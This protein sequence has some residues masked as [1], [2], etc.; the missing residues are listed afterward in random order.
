MEEAQNCLKLYGIRKTTVDELVKRVNIPKG[1][2]YLFYESKE[3]LF[4]EVLCSFHDE[5]QSILI[6][7]FQALDE[8]VCAGKLTELLLDL[9]KRIEG[10]F[11]YRLITNGD[12]ELLLKKLPPEVALSH[13]Q[14]D[15][16]SIEQLISILPCI[17][18]DNIKA[19]SAAM[20]AIFLSMLHKHEIGDE[21]FDDA[22]KLLING[23]VIQ[24]FEGGQK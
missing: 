14:K 20:R 8:H 7:D 17:K 21:V 18:K 1:T 5:L 24:M 22:L 10:S 4:Y 23:I 15:D 13:A 3:M 2:F 9:Y 11:L 16:F 12:L 19:F 6:H